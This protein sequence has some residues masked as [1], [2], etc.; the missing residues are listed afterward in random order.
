M[1]FIP[2]IETLR[3][4]FSSFAQRGR[5]DFVDRFGGG[6][7]GNA[8]GSPFGGSPAFV[9]PFR[10]DTEDL[11]RNV[12][13]TGSKNINEKIESL[14]EERISESVVR[15]TPTFSRAVIEPEET[16]RRFNETEG[17]IA[18]KLPKVQSVEEASA[19]N[20]AA[21]L[22]ASKSPFTGFDF[23]SIV[24]DISRFSNRF[25]PTPEQ[26]IEEPAPTPVYEYNPPPPYEPPPPPPYNPPPPPPPPPAVTEATP[27][28]EEPTYTK[29]SE[30]SDD[31]FDTIDDIEVRGTSLDEFDTID[32]IEVKGT[33]YDDS[34]TIDDI[35]VIGKTPGSK[36]KG[37]K[38][39]KVVCCDGENKS[40]MQER[41]EQNLPGNGL[42]Y[43]GDTG[44]NP[45]EDFKRMYLDFYTGGEG[46][47]YLDEY[48]KYEE[49]RAR[50]E[51]L[52]LSPTSS[53]S[54][55]ARDA[56]DIMRGNA[57][58]SDLRYNQTMASTSSVDNSSKPIVITN[59]NMYN[60]KSDSTK[61]GSV[62]S[63]DNTLNRLASESSNHPQYSGFR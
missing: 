23:S 19:V 3:S 21:A 36:G 16:F 63:N 26:I 4:N 5:S 45:W 7:F 47:K 52:S 37:S 58:N 62:F 25:G 14:I 17:P 40:P 55:V 6:S 57:E 8:F 24:P 28:R 32:D 53:L 1:A 38:N 31:E 15:P 51:G 2:N 54:S 42:R 12:A 59:N 60:A 9:Q 27:T 22:N 30:E 29:A 11:V 41:Y 33:T 35:D 39:V 50:E 61:T 46:A 48:G 34:E 13:V 10:T 43:T 56:G 49:Q 20:V 44:D 18:S